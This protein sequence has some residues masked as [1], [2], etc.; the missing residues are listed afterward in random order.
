M[1]LRRPFADR[2][3]SV[4]LTTGACAGLGASILATG[5]ASS[6]R[7][8][9]SDSVLSG[10]GVPARELGPYERLGYRIEWKGLPVVSRRQ[11]PM[12]VDVFGDRVVF[13]DTGNTMTV[14]DAATGRSIW[15]A[16]VDNPSSRFIGNARQGDRLFS[17]SD[18]ELFVLDI[19]TGEILE[20]HRLAVVANSGPT[21]AGNIACFG[22]S[23]GQ[24]LGHNLASSFKL[25]GYQLDGA[26]TARP[27]IVGDTVAAVSQRGEV[28]FV[29]P[30]N[31]SSTGITRIFSGLANNPVAGDGTLFIAGTD[32]S[33]YAFSP[34]GGRQLWRVR[35]PYPIVDQPSFVNGRLYVHVPNEGITA[36]AA[37]SGA[38]LWRNAEARGTVLGVR[39]GRLIVWDGATA[40][41]LDQDRGETIEKVPLSGVHTLLMTQPVDGD[42]YVVMRDGWVERHSPR[43]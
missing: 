7:D 17:S 31:G 37:G 40:Y 39:G 27:V 26:I 34:E 16:E 30:A 13:Q 20:R 5:C 42:L 12:F 8:R 23:A 10:A 41:V 33:V 9:E 1:P 4:L 19:R 29:N 11:T 6:P 18:N 38:V 36:Y 35:T 43:R 21:L 15:A 25:W 22:G 32:Q 28:V 24:L 2:L 3:R 14:M